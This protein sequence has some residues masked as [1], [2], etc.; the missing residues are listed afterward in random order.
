[1]EDLQF[2]KLL[3]LAD[4]YRYVRQGC[5]IVPPVVLVFSLSII[6]Y[7]RVIPFFDK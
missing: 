6:L 5:S 7:Q 4:A 1:M 2:R 3:D